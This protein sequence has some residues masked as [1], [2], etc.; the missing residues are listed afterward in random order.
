MNVFLRRLR[1]FFQGHDDVLVES[2]SKLVLQCT[3]CGNQSTGLL[4]DT[5][6]PKVKGAKIIRFK[7]RMEA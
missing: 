3:S 2:P 6:R 7:K 5:P 1:C 4:L